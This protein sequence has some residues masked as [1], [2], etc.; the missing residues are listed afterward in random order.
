VIYNRELLEKY[1]VKL[2]KHCSEWLYSLRTFKHISARHLDKS[3]E[4][5]MMTLIHEMVHF[6][7]QLHDS[8]KKP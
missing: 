7:C 3:I 8:N 6:Y 1:I 4:N 5:I 2:E